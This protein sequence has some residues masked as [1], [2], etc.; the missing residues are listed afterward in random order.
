M[1]SVLRT[2]ANMSDRFALRQLEAHLQVADS[3]KL[4][5]RLNTLNAARKSAAK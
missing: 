1:L 2:F 3:M 5:N 4:L